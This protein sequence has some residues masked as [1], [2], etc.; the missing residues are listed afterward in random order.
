MSSGIPS[1]TPSRQQLS[2]FQSTA[3][4]LGIC[5]LFAVI[6]YFIG[7]KTF[8]EMQQVADANSKKVIEISTELNKAETR[9]KQAQ[10][11]IASLKQE[12][13]SQTITNKKLE[14]LDAQLKEL[15]AAR[16]KQDEA[17]KALSQQTSAVQGDR[18]RNRTQVVEAAKIGSNLATELAVLKED[19]TKWK[20]SH[21]SLSRGNDGPKIAAIP[22]LVAKYESLS[23]APVV[24]FD[25]YDRWNEQ[26]AAIYPR[27]KTAYEKKEFLVV[28]EDDIRFL[29]ELL[30][31]VQSSRKTL[32]QHQRS[33]D[34]IIASVKDADPGQQSLKETI[35]SRQAERDAAYLQ[36]LA[37]SKQAAADAV[38]AEYAQKIADKQREQ[39]EILNKQ[40]LQAA[41]LQTQQKQTELDRITEEAEEV[42]KAREKALLVQEYNRDRAAIESLLAPFLDLAITQ[43]SG[44]NPI[45][46]G[47]IR[48]QTSLGALQASGALNDTRAGLDF[49]Y[50]VGGHPA[51]MRKK[52][53][54]PSFVSM[55]PIPNESV[56]QQVQ[57]AQQLLVK[58]G[59]LLVEKGMLSQ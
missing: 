17:L 5:L 45:S 6:L 20:G 52:G 51:N 7:G 16:A 59:E 13:E 27:I 2:V 43:P 48:R 50:H 4:A 29:S 23:N 36:Q 54:F 41:E 25:D 28:S 46:K 14:E 8:L 53:S 11:D 34:L 9:H 12:V 10:S 55:S 49:L 15:V 47:G 38:D 21:A 33:L 3:I 30:G 58:Y 22:D 1:E 44:T 56:R 24:S 40:R 42:R 18:A 19:I 35:A 32:R 31:E 57:R 39:S 26:L 37:E